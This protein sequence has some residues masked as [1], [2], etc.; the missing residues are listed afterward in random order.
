M[1]TLSRMNISLILILT[2]VSSRAQFGQTNI[3]SAG[4]NL[5]QYLMSTIISSTEGGRKSKVITAFN[6]AENTMGKRF[7]FDHW[8]NADSI[9]TSSHEYISPESY[10]FNFDKMTGRLLVSQDKINIMALAASG[11]NSFILHDENVKYVF[12]KLPQIDSSKFYLALV[13]SNTGHSLYKSSAVKFIMANFR[14]DGVIQSGNRYDEYKEE[15]EYYVVEA[16]TKHFKFINFRARV[17]KTVLFSEK[18]Q[19]DKFFRASWDKK[20]NEEFLVNLI[21]YVNRPG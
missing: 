5:S 6:T 19:T 18:V 8:V 21:N 3:R 10:F 13:K 7:M 9:I 12:D 2:V 1:C 20:I 15:N 17:I 16:S 11:I 4:G 14:D